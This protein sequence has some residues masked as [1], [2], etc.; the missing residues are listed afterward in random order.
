MRLRGLIL[1]GAIAGPVFVI[2]VLLPDYSVPDFDPRAHLLS[3]L[4]LGR[5]GIQ[6][7]NFVLAGVLN[8]F[9]AIGLRRKLHGDT[10]ETAP[11]VLIGLYGLFLV[12]VGA[13]KTDPANG[14]PPGADSPGQPSGHAVISC[15]RRSV[16]FPYTDSCIGCFCS[17]LLLFKE[18]RFAC[19]R[20]A[21]AVLM[22]ACFFGGIHD[23][24]WMARSLRLATLIGWSG[25][26]V[27]AMR[28][29]NDS[30][31]HSYNK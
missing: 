3:Q 24:R 23:A 4:S 2:A 31:S 28:L 21:R 29:C 17:P 7:V 11:P 14:F 8:L 6:I 9:Y 22:S 5:W 25:A 12:V 20:A 26:S 13:F 18:K 15:P 30:V 10:A 19:Y 1:C 27:V 16:H